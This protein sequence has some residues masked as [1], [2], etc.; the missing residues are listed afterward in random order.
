MLEG[1]AQQVLR[2]PVLLAAGVPAAWLDGGGAGI[3]GLRTAAGPL[4]YRLRRDGDALLLEVDDT[5]LRLPEGGLV[6][7]WPLSAKPGGVAVEAGEAGW[8][9]GELRVTAL[10][11][12]VRIGIEGE[13]DGD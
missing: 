9:E 10:P 4:A 1:V 12:R 11:A 6:L 3:A 13:R 2:Q 8:D 5:G 7:P